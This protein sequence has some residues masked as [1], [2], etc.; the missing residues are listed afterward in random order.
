MADSYRQEVL[1]VLLAQLLQERGIVSTPESIVT[2]GQQ[3]ARRM[4]DVIVRFHGLR[5]A[6]EGEVGDAMT[7]E[8]RALDS[9]RNRVE[10]GIAH[11]GVA[12]IYPAELRKEDFSVLKSKLARC[13]LAIAIVTESE[14]T[15]FATGTVDYLDSALR[16]AFDH[17][18]REDVVAQAVEILDAGIGRFSKTIAAK[19]GVVGRVAEVLGIHE[20]P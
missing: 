20:L 15:G 6:I 14:D 16:H 1:N 5:V 13:D 8:R 10:E 11:I 2:S 4:P 19:G 9:A 3:Q 12:V 17:L 18:V 7:A